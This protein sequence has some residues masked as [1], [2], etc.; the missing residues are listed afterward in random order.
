MDAI[1][2]SGKPDRIPNRVINTCFLEKISGIGLE[3]TSP[4][5]VT[6]PELWYR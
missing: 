5:K 4:E 1:T 6:I 2:L 3:E